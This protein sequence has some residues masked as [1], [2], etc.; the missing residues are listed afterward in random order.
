MRPLL[1]FAFLIATTAP[2]L[3]QE[4]STFENHWK[5]T[6]RLAVEDGA[7][8]SDPSA[9]TA[10]VIEPVDGTYVRLR[11]LA[12]GLYLHNE[13]GLSVGPIEPGWW[14]AMWEL[15]PISGDR[16]RIKNR[17]LGTYLHNE[18]GPLELGEIQ[19]G[20]NSAMWSQQPVQ[21]Q[22]AFSKSTTAVES[23]LGMFH[24]PTE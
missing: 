2:V 21:T 17:W 13:T 22:M 23:R 12:T 14:S 7:L 11:N 10:W 9:S 5:P 1:L 8:V 19:S 4:V 6:E 3:S 18:N 20:W 16:V 15:E 24:V